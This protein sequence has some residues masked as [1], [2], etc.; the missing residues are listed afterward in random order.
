MKRFLPLFVL[1]FCMPCMAINTIWKEPGYY[2][3]PQLG[4][5]RADEGSGFKE[6]AEGI[7]RGTQPAGDMIHQG[8]FG[9]RVYA[10]VQLVRYFGIETGYTKFASNE[11]D[12]NNATGASTHLKLKSSAWDFMARAIFPL[13]HFFIY[14]K[15]GFARMLVDLR[16]QTNGAAVKSSNHKWQPAYGAGLGFAFTKRIAIDLSWFAIEGENKVTLA[17]ATNSTFGHFIPA[18]NFFSLGLMLKLM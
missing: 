2:F 11:Y 6:F 9:W 7:S 5:S 1:F 18:A 4:Y 13:G 8:G 12:A 3:G 15:A 16:G 10:G 17:N 14:G